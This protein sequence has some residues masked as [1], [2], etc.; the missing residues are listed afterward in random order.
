MK[1][2]LIIEDDPRTTL[3]LAVRL[4]G[5]GY[6]TWTASDG[7]KGMQLAIR[8]RPDL[9]ILDI[10]LPGGNGL[11][12]AETLRRK[13]QTCRIPIIFLTGSKER[14]LRQK[15]MDLGAAGLLEKPYESEELLLMI[16]MAFDR[17]GRPHT[18]HLPISL[19]DRES[20][21]KRILI[22]EDDE[23]IARALAVR[24][25]AAGYET[26]MAHDG[27]AGFRAAVVEKPD[28]VLLDISL[29]AGDGFTVAERI[30]NNIPRPIPVIFLTASKRPEFRQRAQSLG[31]VGFFEKPFEANALLRAVNK[32]V[33]QFA[34]PN[35][36]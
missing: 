25:T 1:T 27:L 9:I 18:Q 23:R 13:P 3:A 26:S 22:V 7:I 12:L 4:K 35:A 36:T 6:S 34:G 16:Q 5:Q 31:A 32:A 28:L 19:P 14:N 10:G 15:V 30:Q 17:P 21:P 8:T 33:S 2:I 29:A 24:L 11:E 20:S